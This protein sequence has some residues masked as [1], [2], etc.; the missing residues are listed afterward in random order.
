[1]R[2]YRHGD[3]FIKEVTAFNGER[4]ITR[5]MENPNEI[6]LLKGEATG[7]THKLTTTD[8]NRLK[9]FENEIGDR[10]F[11]VDGE[12]LLVHEEHKPIKITTGKYAVIRQRVYTP[13]AITYVID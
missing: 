11:E 2:N 10:F 5:W 9:F 6:V 8:G 7:H 1:M 3:L 13:K 4:V 12:V